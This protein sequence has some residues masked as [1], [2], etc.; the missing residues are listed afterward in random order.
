MV[1][2]SVFQTDDGGSIPPTRSKE[3]TPRQWCFFFGI[4]IVESNGLKR[5]KV[6]SSRE[7]R[8]RTINKQL[9]AVCCNL[10][11]QGRQPKTKA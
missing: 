7:N 10:G 9:G 4:I 11:Q 8:K 6:A 2:I 1:I 3:R 5:A